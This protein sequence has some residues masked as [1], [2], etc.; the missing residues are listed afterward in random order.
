MPLQLQ[1]PSVRS[2]LRRVGGRVAVAMRDGLK[3]AAFDGRRQVLDAVKLSRYRWTA[4]KFSRV[5]TIAGGYRVK[6]RGV[7]GEALNLADRGGI[8]KNVV[9]PLKPAPRQYY[10]STKAIYDVT[11]RQA[12]KTSFKERQKLVYA[13]S[14]TNLFVINKKYIIR[15]EGEATELIGV[16]R[17]RAIYRG[18][19]INLRHHW[20]HGATKGFEKALARMR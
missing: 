12:G 19:K 16:I 9:M 11:Q 2:A 20:T 6:V 4:R 7:A 13:R 18:G 17:P 10:P 14:P 3:S 15:S 5:Q 1:A 8:K